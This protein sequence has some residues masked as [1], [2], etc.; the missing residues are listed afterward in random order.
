MSYS[1]VLNIGVADKC[2]D[3]VKYKTRKL[4]VQF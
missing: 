3:T 4:K 1:L 2:T